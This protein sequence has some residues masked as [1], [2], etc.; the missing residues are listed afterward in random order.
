MMIHM[1]D[2]ERD[3]I[4]MRTMGRTNQIDLMNRIGMSTNEED[5]DIKDYSSIVVD[6]LLDS[7]RVRSIL[8]LESL[9]I[10]GKN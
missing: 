1:K 8:D 2:T 10:F 6:S 7:F 5:D 9:H 3:A 4:L